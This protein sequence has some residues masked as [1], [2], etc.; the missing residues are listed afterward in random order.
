MTAAA[1]S[2]SKAG[3]GVRAVER[4]PDD[5]SIKGDFSG[6]IEYTERNLDAVDQL[7]DANVGRFC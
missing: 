3:I 7:V 1:F 5:G 2:L 4:D 6:S